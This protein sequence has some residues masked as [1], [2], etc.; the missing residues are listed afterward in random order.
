ML[1][2]Q[3]TE[4]AAKETLQIMLMGL[5]RELSPFQYRHQS[6]NVDIDDCDHIL[7][8]LYHMTIPNPKELG[9]VDD[10]KTGGETMNFERSMHYY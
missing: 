10:F 6:P 2:H 4:K 9:I 3:N 8:F 5:Y 1:E 7:D